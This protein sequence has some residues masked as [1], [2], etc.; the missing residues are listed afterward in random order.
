MLLLPKIENFFLVAHLSVIKI[1]FWEKGP[2]D[3][4]KSDITD[5]SQQK[6]VDSEL[7]CLWFVKANHA[8]CG[9]LFSTPVKAL[10]MV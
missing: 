2:T 8:T 4:L 9:I 7:N 10:I 5:I 1:H 3:L 6:E